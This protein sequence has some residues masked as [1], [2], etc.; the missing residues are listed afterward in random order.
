MLLGPTIFRIKVE[1]LNQF[2]VLYSLLKKKKKDRK[3]VHTVPI[4][5]IND[6]CI[7]GTYPTETGLIISAEG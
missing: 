5:F 2:S 3:V 7:V 6:C 4:Q 1:P